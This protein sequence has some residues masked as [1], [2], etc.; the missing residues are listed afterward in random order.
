M[1]GRIVK[2]LKVFNSAIGS[3][4]RSNL[5]LSNSTKIT[6]QKIMTRQT[7]NKNLQTQQIQQQQHLTQTRWF[8]PTFLHISTNQIHSKWNEFGQPTN[9][10]HPHLVDENE[11]TP[12]TTKQEYQDRRNRLMD[13]MPLNSILILST[14]PE[15]YKTEDIPHDHRPNSHF[16]YLTGYMEP[17]AVLVFCNR[18]R[19]NKWKFLY[20]VILLFYVCFPQFMFFSFQKKKINLKMNK[21]TQSFGYSS[22]QKT[23][24]VQSGMAQDLV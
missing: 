13:Q 15:L 10:T 22:E 18:E 19:K 21:K 20:F 5:K 4:A 11:L 1:A 9:K 12:Q 3:N 8:T 23:L 16:Y 7:A 14:N 17:T 2:T 24:N 6:Q